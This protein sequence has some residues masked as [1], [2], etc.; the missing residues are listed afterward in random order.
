MSNLSRYRFLITLY[1]SVIL[2][3]GGF[4]I[5]SIPE[6]AKGVDVK[7]DIT[8]NPT[9]W[10]GNVNITGDIYI[11]SGANLTISPGTVVE[12]KGFYHIYVNS[13]AS[14]YSNGS[15]GNEVLIYHQSQLGWGGIILNDTSSTAVFKYTIITNNSKGIQMDK[16]GSLLI[17]SCIILENLFGVQGSYMDPVIKNSTFDKNS[18]PIFFLLNVN[19][20]V[21]NNKFQN[22]TNSVIWQNSQGQPIFDNNLVEYTI[23]GSN[24]TGVQLSNTNIHFTNNTI[25]NVSGYGVSLSQSS[26]FVY[27]NVFKGNGFP[28]SQFAGMLVSSTNTAEVS[29]IESN[30][31]ASNAIGVTFERDPQ[32]WSG[33]NISGDFINNKIYNNTQ[34]GVMIRNFS[35]PNFV[36]NNVFN[37]Y[38]GIGV[39]DSTPIIENSTVTGNTDTDFWLD[40]I[41]S[42]PCAPLS[43]NTTFGSVNFS[44]YSINKILKVKW[45]VNISVIENISPFNPVPY[46]EVTVKSA[47]G[48]IEFKKDTDVTGRINWLHTIEKVMWLGAIKNYSP[49]EITVENKT[50][51]R[52]YVK[53]TV[54]NVL[55]TKSVD[56]TI[57]IDRNYPPSIVTGIT[58]YSTHDNTPV[59]TWSP[60]SDVNGDPVTYYFRLGTV[61]GW[62][63][64]IPEAAVTGTNYAVTSPLIYGMNY[65]ITLKAGDNRFAN[66][67][68]TTVGL[69][70]TN[71]HPSTPV[72]TTTPAE[73]SVITDQNISVVMTTP[74][75]DD[76][77]E[78]NI[79]GETIRYTVYVDIN[80]IRKSSYTKLY[81]PEGMVNFE[82]DN[83]DFNKGDEI[84]IT[85]IPYDG[86]GDDWNASGP[87]GTFRHPDN[88]TAALVTLH[89]ENSAPRINSSITLDDIIMNEDSEYELPYDFQTIF[90]DPDKDQISFEYENTENIDIEY[91][92]ASGRITIRP[93]PDY[94]SPAGQPDIVI[95]K[96]NDSDGG[97]T[98][99]SFYVTVQEVNDLP[100]IHVHTPLTAYQDKPFYINITTTDPSDPHDDSSL[101]MT[102][103]YDT[104][105]FSSEYP[106]VKDAPDNKSYY[107]IPGNADVGIFELEINATDGKGFNT[108]TIEIEV[109]N[110]NDKP[111]KPV[112]ISPMGSN[113]DLDQIYFTTEIIDF[114]VILDDLDLYVSNSTEQLSVSWTSNVSSLNL[115]TATKFNTKIPYD[116]HHN[117]T[118]TVTDSGGLAN[119]AHI[120]LF[121][122]DPFLEDLPKSLLVLPEDQNEIRIVSNK[123][124]IT[125]NWEPKSHK[126]SDF[127][128]YD[129]YL[130]KIQNSQNIIA[131]DLNTTE[132]TIELDANET[133]YWWV[134]PKLG[135]KD[136]VIGDCFS[137]KWYF[138][139]ED[140]S[141]HIYDFDISLEPS[142]FIILPGEAKIVTVTISNLGNA[143][144]F[145]DVE[146]Q[147]QGE[148]QGI[149]ISQSNISSLEIEPGT[150]AVI[151]ITVTADEKI[152]P[153]IVV[154]KAEASSQ[155][156]VDQ[157]KVINRKAEITFDVNKPVES[158]SEDFSMIIYSGLAI[159]VVFIIILIILLFIKIEKNK[160]LTN[161]Q[162]R[163]IFNTI[164]D[165]PGIHFREI[166]RVHS[167]SPGTLSYHLNVLEKN[168]YIKSIQKGEYRCFYT[169]DDKSDF[170]IK[171]STIQQKILFV[172]NENPGISLSELTEA[173]GKN[174][175]VLN[176]HTNILEDVGA[177]VKEKKG[178]VSIF[179]VTNIADYE[180]S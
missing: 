42:G 21:I 86:H 11:N 31:F 118:V 66:S 95:L 102:T 143:K 56:I 147:I 112:I 6:Q 87:S 127:F 50:V 71:V 35:Y 99:L 72:I 7:G 154:L 174:K 171:L 103:N 44:S 108:V 45:F 180:I 15:S 115:G 104:W 58:P 134:I 140:L 26:A 125:L 175:M 8:G 40:Y 34:Y 160:V 43:L 19:G 141:Q 176:Y 39:F 37:N 85:V 24:P 146:F 88:G 69:N 113:G 152:E 148:I 169:F 101:I 68:A 164:K 96:A 107:F 156:A 117:I 76:T 170:K 28:S 161:V 53:K 38:R 10:S 129:V 14:I 23:A 46:T 64:V 135:G 173:V 155:R 137:G 106:V 48:S 130:D 126:Y 49:Y 97:I 163:V 178:R 128:V 41:A 100:L 78:V 2:L 145:I 158:Q 12:F 25:R 81:I 1:V 74:S 110:I 98:E 83:H 79:F 105:V 139:I 150:S 142:E 22:N 84:N 168:S 57:P 138:T 70:I 144:D 92:P 136:G 90:R 179:F 121:V 60:S 157:G 77:D 4:G 123:T 109:L 114:E 3:S 167:L 30:D 75:F 165:Q 166:M 5:Y 61:P 65:Y 52:I 47:L 132:F 159:S 54:K 111:K 13:S 151:Y 131:A 62:D 55:V 63:D 133:Y 9:I 177:I 32:P 36:N 93:R 91:I 59:I 27:N 17:D 51:P 89:V 172:I 67:T 80:N 120:N 153:G 73:G 124:S 82:I 149:S 16:G 162:R 20:T 29:K 116:G 119:S 33:A 94:F 18:F 122:V